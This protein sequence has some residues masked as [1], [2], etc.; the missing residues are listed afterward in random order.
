RL[1]FDFTH[2]EPVSRDALEEIE[3]LANRRFAEDEPVRAYETTFE[4]ARSQGAIALFGEKYGEIV[5]VVEVGDYSVELCGG[6]HVHHTGEI[7]LV[8]VVSEGSIGSGFRRVEALVGPDALKQVNVD[9]RLL[10]EVLEAVGGGEPSTAPERVRNAVARIKQLESELGKVRKAERGEAVERLLGQ[11]LDVDGVSLV[12]AEMDGE[13]ADELREMAQAL[14]NGLERKGS[15]AA[16]LGSTNEGKA[17]LIA[18]CTNDLISRGVTA[19]AML[20]RAAKVI[21][22]GAGGKP[23]LAFAGGKKAIALPEAL[24]AIPDHLVSLLSD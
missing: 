11:A 1:R 22:G 23:N 15:G 2:F 3:Y 12:V 6:T 8:R 5:R 13:G 24:A 10:E 19:P 9:R 18:A 21:G 17:L 4:F 16:V 7:A 20:E 14:R